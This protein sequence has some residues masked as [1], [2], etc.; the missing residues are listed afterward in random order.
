MQDTLTLTCIDS[1]GE[2]TQLMRWVGLMLEAATKLGRD[3]AKVNK[4]K[5]W[6]ENAG[7]ADVKEMR[8]AWPMNTWPRG[9]HYKTLSAWAGQ[10]MKDGL[11]GFSMAALT[12][13]L[14]WTAEEVNVLLADVRRDLDD[15]NIHAY[16]P[17]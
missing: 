4:Y 3:W 13:A 14:G 6:M 8:F 12:R 10:N 17:M 1:S 7:F 15:R 2:G 16:M 11:E 5:G 9:K